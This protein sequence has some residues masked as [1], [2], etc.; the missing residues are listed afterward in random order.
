[1]AHQMEMPNWQCTS[2]DPIIVFDGFPDDVVPDVGPILMRCRQ[3]SFTFLGKAPVPK[4]FC[5]L[6]DF[7]AHKT[8]SS[9]GQPL[10]LSRRLSASADE[11]IGPS[12]A[13]RHRG[14][15]KP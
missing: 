15:A 3:P 5:S 4:G 7:S 6:S 8:V 14:F 9:F 11:L 12:N 10:S 1:M 2:H 13:L